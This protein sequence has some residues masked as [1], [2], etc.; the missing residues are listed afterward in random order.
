M[1][2][3]VSINLQG[4]TIS[5]LTDFR[6]DTVA[7]EHQFF[8][9]TFNRFLLQTDFGMTAQESFYNTPVRL[10][11][12]TQSGR[13]RHVT[14]NIISLK[15]MERAGHSPEVTIAGT[16][17]SPAGK[18]PKLNRFLWAAILLPLLVMG[19]VFLYVHLLSQKLVERRGTID[20]YSRSSSYKGTRK[21]SFRIAPFQASF[22]RSY[23]RPI[24]NRPSEHIDALFTSSYDGYHPDSTGQAVRFFVLKDD[25]DKL[26]TK[27]SIV[28]FFNLQHADKAYSSLDQS[29][30]ILYFAKDQI[31]WYFVWLIY[32]FAEIALLGFVFYYYKMF[33]F[34]QDPRK[35]VLSW[36]YGFL[37][38]ILNVP[39]ILMFI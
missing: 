13:L 27:D 11:F 33:A 25:V 18:F 9:L 15:Y 26:P 30:D 31:W 2:K 37:I 14:G 20:S 34:N 3:P 38:L 8:Q 36:S 16:F 4:T 29:L 19:S 12:L 35:R 23:Y 10:N 5:E 17:Y 7:N 6:Y 28:P 24:V 1:E 32:A 39:V 22:K 21:H